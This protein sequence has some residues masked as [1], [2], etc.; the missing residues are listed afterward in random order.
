MDEFT[1]DQLRELW[2]EEQIAEQRA[3][4]RM[5]ADELKQEYETFNWN[6]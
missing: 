2:H 3:S 1:E 5:E 6:L 4:D